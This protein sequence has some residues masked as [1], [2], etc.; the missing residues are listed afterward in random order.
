MR[1][2]F[3]TSLDP[4]RQLLEVMSC[5]I[6]RQRGQNGLKLLYCLLAACLSAVNFW[7]AYKNNYAR[8]PLIV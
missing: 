6:E 5:Y 8:Q 2:I 1:K 7:V 3:D 4:P